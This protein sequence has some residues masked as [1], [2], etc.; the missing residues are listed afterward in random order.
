MENN[1][2][3]AEVVDRKE[4]YYWVRL[5]EGYWIIAEWESEQWWTI[6]SDDV[7][8]DKHFEEIDERQIC[9]S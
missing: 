8:L 3:A 6:V 7:F 4:G 1:K 9:R 5:K 2:G